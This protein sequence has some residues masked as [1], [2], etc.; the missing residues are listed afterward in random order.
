MAMIPYGKHRIDEDDI[1]AVVDVLKSDWLTTGPAVNSF[2]QQVAE[3]SGVCEGVAFSSGTAALHATMHVLGV[4][5]GDE[6]VVPCMTFAATANSVLYAGGTPVF[7]DVLSDTLTISP[8]SVERLLT[9][10]TKAIVA[11]DY[12]GTP[13]RYDELSRLAEKNGIALVSDA[14][15]S[16]GGVYKGRPVGSLADLTCY[17]FHPVKHVAT[18]EGGMV[19]TDNPQLAKALRV[20]R[21]HGI[22]SDARQREQTGAWYYEMTELGY[23]YRIPDIL[24]ALG[25]SQLAKLSASIDRRRDIAKMYD[26]AFAGTAVKPLQ[27]EA[28]CGHAYH[29]YVVQIPERDVA[30]TALRN[31]GIGV[32]VHYIP[33][34]YHPY[35]RKRFNT[36]PGMCPVAEAAYKRI[37][38]L[39]MH[40]GLSDEDVAFVIKSVLDV[41]G[42]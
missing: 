25:I 35:Y 40:P 30:F 31:R 3:L 21:N 5:E 42:R 12:S 13:C 16:L 29:L 26:K 36:G 6:V 15:H 8:D 2:E 39:P 18:G 10:R 20:F 38:T 23:N 22:G 37:I 34:H 33:V 24:C 32:N 7:A 14:C 17:S 4:G 19:V 41:V 11:V 27:A 1:Q 28:F 9:E